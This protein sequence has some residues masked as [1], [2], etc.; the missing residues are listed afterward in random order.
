[1]EQDQFLQ[2]LAGRVGAAVLSN[3]LCTYIANGCL[4]QFMRGFHRKRNIIG[5]ETIAASATGVWRV[6]GAYPTLS[7]HHHHLDPQHDPFW[8]S[9]STSLYVEPRRARSGCRCTTAGPS[10][11]LAFASLVA[12]A[13]SALVF[14]AATRPALVMDGATASRSI[15]SEFRLGRCP[16]L[17]LRC[18][19]I[20]CLV[21]MRSDG[22]SRLYR[23]PVATKS[24]APELHAAAA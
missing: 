15:S 9:A 24:C 6:S 12:M 16:L 7:L 2:R 1:M 18:S 5:V 14:C 19:F 23:R 11:T 20:F 4:K 22:R 3:F 13:N 21:A 8:Y 10:P 17:S